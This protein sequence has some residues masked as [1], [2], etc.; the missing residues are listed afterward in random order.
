P[1]DLDEAITLGTAELARRPSADV[2]FQLARAY[3]RAAR[4]REGLVQIRAALSQGVHDARIYELASRLEAAMGNTPRA[5]MYRR[6]ADAL[7]RSNSGWRYL[8]MSVTAS[9]TSPTVSMAVTQ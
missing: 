6:E 3:H 2:R 9:P 5:D 8:G 1:A 4:P 7:D